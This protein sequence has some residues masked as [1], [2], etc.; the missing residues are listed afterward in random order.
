MMDR[1]LE[2]F[3]QSSEALKN[4]MEQYI[5]YVGILSSIRNIEIESD[6]Q[7]RLS[8]NTMITNFEII[9]KQTR[10][11]SLLMEKESTAQNIVFQVHKSLLS[12]LHLI[13]ISVDSHNSFGIGMS[14]TLINS[15]LRF[16]L[17]NNSNISIQMNMLSAQIVKVHT[18][19]VASE[20][21]NID[22]I[23]ALN[24]LRTI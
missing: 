18:A 6:Y 5:R 4:A 19:L 14:S 2:L 24:Q 3:N 11:I 21:N 12:A 20:F 17:D 1:V 10:R 16:V 9:N 13:E 23:N 8:Q 22:L 7:Q 15:I